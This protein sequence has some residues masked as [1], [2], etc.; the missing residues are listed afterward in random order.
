MP[1][2]ERGDPN[3]DRLSASSLR[4]PRLRET[5]RPRILNPW[6]KQGRG[7]ELSRSRRSC[8]HPQGVGLRLNTWVVSQGWG[9]KSRK[10]RPRY[11][12]WCWVWQG[13]GE[14][15][16]SAGGGWLRPH[17]SIFENQWCQAISPAVGTEPSATRTYRY[18]AYLS[19]HGQCGCAYGGSCD[20]VR[21]LLPH[22]GSQETALRYHA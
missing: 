19:C 12:V 22:K 10:A 20:H 5:R 15:Q 16:L 11:R 1:L 2:V 13:G 7:L 4:G 9:H 6:R 14:T 17:W 21:R 8:G 3:R 18:P